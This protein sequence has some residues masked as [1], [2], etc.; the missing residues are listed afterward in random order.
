M[1]R[2]H[3]VKDYLT[4]YGREL[5]DFRLISFHVSQ[6]EIMG[7]CDK[8]TVRKI[9]ETFTGYEQTIILKTLSIRSR[10]DNCLI[11]AFS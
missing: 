2:A 9:D 4:G 8:N 3:D 5:L 11:S 10:N 7:A 6:V 1:I